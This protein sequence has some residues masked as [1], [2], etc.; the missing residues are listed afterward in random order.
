MQLKKHGVPGGGNQMK[1]TRKK[2][3]KKKAANPSPRSPSLKNQAYERIRFD[4]VTYALEPGEKIS[5]ADLARRYNLGHAPLRSALQRLVEQGLVTNKRRLG[6]VV[7]PIT[8]SDIRDIFQLR[9]ILEPV[10]VELATGRITSELLR[11]LQAACRATYNRRS[12]GRNKKVQFLMANR[13]FCIAVA[14]ACGNERLGA[15]IEHL[16]DLTLRILYLALRPN[17]SE[18]EEPFQANA[19]ILNALTAGD[20]MRARELYAQALEAA[21]KRVLSGILDLPNFQNFN[22]AELDAR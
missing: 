8:I 19:E 9:R 5:E 10:A 14:R 1:T 6:H 12:E 15:A 20:A 11:E 22:V 13:A 16:Q 3:I 21:E 4:I 18:S 17:T 2:V 7:T